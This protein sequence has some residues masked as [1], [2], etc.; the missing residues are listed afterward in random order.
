MEQLPPTHTHP[1]PLT[2]SHPTPSWVP[3]HCA[4]FADTT[5]LEMHL[6]TPDISGNCFQVQ[7]TGVRLTAVYVAQV[8]NITTSFTVHTPAPQSK[9]V[10]ELAQIITTFSR[11]CV[12]GFHIWNLAD[13]GGCPP[14]LADS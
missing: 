4:E 3:S 10:L 11:V 13:C 8:L 14:G 6:G 1:T 2:A 12:G 7:L 9:G 5:G